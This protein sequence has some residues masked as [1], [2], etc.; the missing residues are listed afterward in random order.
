MNRQSQGI[1]FPFKTIR[2]FTNLLVFS[3]TFG[4]ISAIQGAFIKYYLIFLP[5]GIFSRADF[6]KD[7]HKRL[8]CQGKGLKT[9]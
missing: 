7:F 6:L 1:I 3:F 2:E 8:M 5:G 4:S 9:A